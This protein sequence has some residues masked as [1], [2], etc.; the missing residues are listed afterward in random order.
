MATVKVLHAKV[1]ATLQAATVD[2]PPK[3]RL[4]TPLDGE[5]IDMDDTDFFGLDIEGIEVSPD[6]KREVEERKSAPLA[7]VQGTTKQ[8][9]GEFKFKRAS[10][11][12]EQKSFIKNIASQ[13]K[14]W[15]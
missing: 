10:M 4:Q 5:H 11:V 9:F 6:E 14:A 13:T 7:L 2:E 15:R 3:I 12:D 1:A 8:A